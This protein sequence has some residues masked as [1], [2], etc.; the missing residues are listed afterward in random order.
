EELAF[1]FS[2]RTSGDGEEMRELLALSGVPLGDV[3]GDRD[4]CFSDLLGETVAFVIWEGP[5]QLVHLPR[6]RHGLPPHDQVLEVP[7]LAH[8]PLLCPLSLSFSL[9]SLDPSAAA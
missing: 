3:R 4:G 8:G 2:Q 6:Q 5:S 7:D 1:H 9:L